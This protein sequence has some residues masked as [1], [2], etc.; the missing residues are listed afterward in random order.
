[1]TLSIR[2]RAQHSSGWTVSRSLVFARR[3]REEAGLEDDVAELN[4]VF[5]EPERSLH[6]PACEMNSS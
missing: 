5:H 1:M 6:S 2:V 4:T 3:G